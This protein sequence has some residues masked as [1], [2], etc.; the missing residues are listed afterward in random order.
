MRGLWIVV[1]F[2]LTACGQA[3]TGSPP[4]QGPPAAG[5][6]T[7]TPD[8]RASVL[9]TPAEAQAAATAGPPYE[10][11]TGQHI[12]ASLSYTESESEAAGPMV[13]QIERGSCAFGY[14]VRLDVPG[15]RFLDEESAPYNDE[16]HL[17]HAAVA[18]PLAQLAELV[19]AEWGGQYVVLVTDAYDS[20]LEHDLAQ[21][22]P[23]RKYSLHFEGRSVDLIL[24]PLGLERMARLCA[25][26][27]AAGFAWVHNE[28]DHC[29]ASVRA[30]SLCYVCS[31]AAE[32]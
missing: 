14:L 8:I 27:H 2:A 32:P 16:D 21:N 11:Q 7:A 12:S 31:G 1:A 28:G 13:C 3:A 6:P 18:P 26:A 5:G 17:V 20:L 24:V 9:Q 10:L 30:D 22:D 23:N 25:L 19:Q 29:H 15:L 4:P